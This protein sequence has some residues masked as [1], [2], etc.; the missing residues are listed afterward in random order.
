MSVGGRLVLILTY[1]FITVLLKWLINSILWRFKINADISIL[2]KSN[3]RAAILC[4][5]RLQCAN[6]RQ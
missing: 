2:D 4:I 6:L 1:I 3:S 5:R